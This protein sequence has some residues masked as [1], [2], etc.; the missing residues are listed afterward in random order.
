MSF[1]VRIID[2]YC[3]HCKRVETV[4]NWDGMTYNLAPMFHK[5]G[6]YEAMKNKTGG[7]GT[8]AEILFG[9]GVRSLGDGPVYAKDW[10]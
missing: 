3:C 8:P 9:E 1:N 6:F 7:T 4:W 5:A 2:D 10:K